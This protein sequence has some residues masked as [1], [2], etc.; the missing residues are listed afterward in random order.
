MEIPPSVIVA[1]TNTMHI[2]LIIRT[3]LSIY[4]FLRIKGFCTIGAVLPLAL[5]PVVVELEHG[6]AVMDVIASAAGVAEVLAGEEV[7]VAD[8]QGVILVMGVGQGEIGLHSHVSAE[9]ALHLVGDE[10]ASGSGEI[11]LLG[12]IDPPAEGEIG[13]AH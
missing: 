12:E 1:T 7:V 6:I 13:R 10:F 2:A 5:G 4:I 8:D 3:V 9:A 11:Q